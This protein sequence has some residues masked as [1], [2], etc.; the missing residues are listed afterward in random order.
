[1][2]LGVVFK[3]GV[4]ET[5]GIGVGLNLMLIDIGEGVRVGATGPNTPQEQG[6]VSSLQTVLSTVQS[7]PLQFVSEQVSSLFLIFNSMG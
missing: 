7:L 6:V 2:G 4:G 1:M 5:G 3:E